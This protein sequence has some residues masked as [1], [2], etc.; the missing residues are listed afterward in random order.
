MTAAWLALHYLRARPL[1]NVLTALAV[2]AGVA[3]VIA[4]NALST[5]ARHSAR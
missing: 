2:A 3:L 1:L 5:S 4:T